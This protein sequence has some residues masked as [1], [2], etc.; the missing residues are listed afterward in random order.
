MPSLCD[1]ELSHNGIGMSGREC[2]CE[3]RRSLFDTLPSDPAPLPRDEAAMLADLPTYPDTQAVAQE[4]EACCRR[5]QRRGL[6][7][8]HREKDDPIAIRPTLYAGRLP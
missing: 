2:D 7:N 6:V 1:C 4:D 5:L 8:V 3:D